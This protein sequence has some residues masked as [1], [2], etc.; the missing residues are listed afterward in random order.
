MTSESP[1]QVRPA[2]RQRRHCAHCR[3]KLGDDET[4]RVLKADIRPM[5]ACVRCK[6]RID[7]A[8]NG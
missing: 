3:Q 2:S 8:P 4:F 6:T 5:L 1:L 7:G